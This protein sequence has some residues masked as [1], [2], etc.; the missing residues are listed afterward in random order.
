MTFQDFFQRSTPNAP[1]AY[2]ERAQYGA[3]LLKRLASDLKTREVTGLGVRML[4]DCRV[5][6]RLYPQN[7]QPLVADSLVRLPTLLPP[8]ILLRLSWTHLL[9]LI[10]LEDPWK[11]AFYENECLKANW[12]KRQLQRQIGSQLYER[13]GLSTDKHAVIE[14]ARRIIQ[15]IPSHKGSPRL[16]L[17]GVSSSVMTKSNVYR[18]LMFQPP[19]GHFTRRP[20][21]VGIQI[22]DAVVSNNL[23]LNQQRL[24]ISPIQP[25]HLAGFT[26]RDQTALVV[27]HRQIS[28]RP[29]RSKLLPAKLG[30]QIIRNFQC[31]SH[32][33]R[34]A[35]I[36][37]C[38]NLDFNEVPIASISK[39]QRILNHGTE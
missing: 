38:R 30:D 23:A 29:G 5:F 25:G 16:L 9:E 32:N 12:S 4:T 13:T 19:L 36:T 10:R 6:Y 20:G 31:Q 33:R 7:R 11:R 26:Q 28:L 2:Q 1:Y 18:Q 35:S 37:R 34:F 8:A 27:N 39:S 15:S 17:S 22:V 14:H 21:D 24:K 3:G